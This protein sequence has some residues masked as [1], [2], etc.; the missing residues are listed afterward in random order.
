MGGIE[1][2]HPRERG[3][4]GEGEERGRGCDVIIR[5]AGMPHSTPREGIEIPESLLLDRV[6]YYIIPFIV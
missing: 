5:D 1:T 6:L 2:S 4:A 3:R